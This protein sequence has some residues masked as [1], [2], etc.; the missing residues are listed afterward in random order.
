MLNLGLSSLGFEDR[1]SRFRMSG[2]HSITAS[3]LGVCNLQAVA[4]LPEV[5]LAEDQQ[6]PSGTLFGSRGYDVIPHMTTS[7]PKCVDYGNSR[8]TDCCKKGCVGVTEE[9][10]S[11]WLFAD[12]G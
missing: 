1:C 4:L 11:P 10:G 8:A 3:G 9:D 5:R 6:S 7:V 2:Y 12:T